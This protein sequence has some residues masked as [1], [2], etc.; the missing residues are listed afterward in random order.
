MIDIHC[1]ILPGI[2]DGAQ[3][4]DDSLK[5]AKQA[6]SEGIHTIIAT[7]HNQNGKYINEKLSVIERVDQLNLQLK[8]EAIPLTILP[9]QESRIYGELIEDYINDKVLSLNNKNKYVFIEFPSNQVPRYSEQLLFDVQ[10][11]GLTPIIVHPER[12]VKFIENPDL[13]YNLVNKGS[14]TQVTAGSLTGRFG[15]K[16]KKFSSDIIQAN[17]AHAIASDAHNISGRNFFM[18][19]A[20]EVLEKDFGLDMLYL[21]L[22]NSE[23]IAHGNVCFKEAPEKITRKKFLGIF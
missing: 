9:G 14:L 2:D 11:E 20:M 5:M 23:A 22:D 4:L 1:H 17:L 8:K 19:E 6:V 12:N 16:I 7:P 10:A 21:F 15:K 3:T 13:L 18:A